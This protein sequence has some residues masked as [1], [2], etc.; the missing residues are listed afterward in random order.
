LIV[1]PEFLEIAGKTEKDLFY[2]LSMSIDDRGHKPAPAPI[3]AIVRFLPGR[4]QFL[5][6][7]YFY[8]KRN[9]DTRQLFSPSR[10]DELIIYCEDRETA[11]RVEQ[12]TLE[13]IGS[14]DS[15]RL[16][17][18]DV[19]LDVL[20]EDHQPR[21]AGSIVIISFFPSIRWEETDRIF[22]GID[23]RLKAA[24]IAGAVHHIYKYPNTPSMERMSNQNR[25]SI[26]V[27]NLEM[28]TELRDVVKQKFGI[29]IDLARV[30]SL[31]N[32]Q[33][34]GKLTDTLSAVIIFVCSLTVCIFMG[35]ILYI[36]LYKNRKHL[37][38]LK[39]F[40]VPSV[41]LRRIYLMRLGKSLATITLI[42]GVLAIAFGYTHLLREAISVWFRVD[43]AFGYFDLVNWY[44]LVFVLSL[45]LFNYITLRFSAD[46]ILKM[47]PG[48]LIYDRTGEN[49]GELESSRNVSAPASTP[50]VPRKVGGR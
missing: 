41:I 24:G 38:M 35:Y 18:P 34:V 20:D 31:N 33:F 44:M 5:S 1:T 23:A 32:Y 47:S 12:I 49:A 15:L 26:H 42:S 21:I 4:S 2:D 40:G 9:L 25:L 16:R 22:E 39:A 17:S 45:V 50:H 28:V 8:E 13:Y 14:I 7:P 6:T 36:F 27:S 3:R 46:S 37:G 11:Q 30:E 48:D 29:E 43:R 10:C 19:Y